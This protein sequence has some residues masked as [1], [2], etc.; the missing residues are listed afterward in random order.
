MSWPILLAAW[1]LAWDSPPPQTQIVLAHYTG[2]G[3]IVGALRVL[4][5]STG[6]PLSEMFDIHTRVLPNSTTTVGP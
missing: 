4:C 5:L 6:G 1:S 3:Q 2:N